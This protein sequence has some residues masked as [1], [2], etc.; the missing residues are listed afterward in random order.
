M[1]I[2]SLN[3]ASDRARP[4]H[5]TPRAGRH[6]NALLTACSTVEPAPEEL[7]LDTDTSQWLPQM[8]RQQR[9]YLRLLLF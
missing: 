9:E 8:A 7:S 4:R 6:R 5:W 3:F 2:L 1:Q